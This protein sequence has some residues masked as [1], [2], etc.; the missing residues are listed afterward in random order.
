MFFRSIICKEVDENMKKA[1]KFFIVLGVVLF[2]LFGCCSCSLLNMGKEKQSYLRIHIRA[3]SNLEKDQAVKYLVKDKVVEYIT[4][5][6]AESKTKED[7]K[8]N[9]I[10]KKNNIE[11][12]VC[13]IL[14]NE[15]FF[16]G[17]SMEINNEFFPARNYGELTLE[18]DYYDAL[19]IKLGSGVG[20]N[21][22]C[23]VYPPLCFVN[24][25][26][27]NSVVYKSKLVEIIKKFIGG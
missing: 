25:N 22:W 26:N 19:I 15:G 16:Y 1:F 7:L 3:N 27:S 2:G 21:W 10:N 5:I 12:F 4:P 11:K 17:C 23:V 18:A 14:K 13:E 9:L 6:I 24:Q 8:V 20:D